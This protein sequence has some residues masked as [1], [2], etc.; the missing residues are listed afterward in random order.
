[1]SWKKNSQRLIRSLLLMMMRRKRLCER[2]QDRVKNLKLIVE[3]QSDA[4]SEGLEDDDLD[5]IN[6]NI[7]A[8][9]KKVFYRF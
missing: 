6:E 8:S 2:D 9:S 1:M 7:G 4:E 5:L 3:R